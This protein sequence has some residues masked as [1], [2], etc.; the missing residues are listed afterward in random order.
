[1]RPTNCREKVRRRIERQVA[2]YLKSGGEI[3]HVEPGASGE[4]FVKLDKRTHRELLRKQ[5]I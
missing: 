2:E 1:M 4:V 3:T 5:R